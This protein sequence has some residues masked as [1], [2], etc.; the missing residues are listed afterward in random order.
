MK[1]FE[2]FSITIDPTKQ[3][4][5]SIEFRRKD[6]RAVKQAIRARFKCKVPVER[7]GGACYRV[8]L[9]SRQYDE[10]AIWL[11]YHSLPHVVRR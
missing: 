7:L 8:S 1:S 11:L 2:R 4:M 9:D 6:A 10:A 5:F 3:P